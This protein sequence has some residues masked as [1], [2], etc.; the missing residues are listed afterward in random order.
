MNRLLSK[1]RD[2]AW[3]RIGVSSATL[4]RAC[5]IVLVVA[6]VATIIGWVL[7]FSARRT[8]SEPV[9]PVPVGDSAPR[10][11]A[12]SLTSSSSRP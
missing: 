6:L 10:T 1:L 5:T 7:E 9:R 4:S 12:A 2:R 3:P 11:Q 8:P